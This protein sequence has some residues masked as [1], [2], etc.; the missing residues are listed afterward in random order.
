VQ[1]IPNIND[2][3]DSCFMMLR[4]L[5]VGAAFPIPMYSSPA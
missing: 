1:K 2:Q 5:G 3:L 4:C